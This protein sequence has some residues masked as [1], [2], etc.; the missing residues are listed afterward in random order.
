MAEV[1]PKKIEVETPAPAP[2]PETEVATETPKDVAEEKAVIPLTPPPTEDKP[3][4]SKAL[5][6]IE[7]NLLS[8][9]LA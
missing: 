1:E 6:V 3:D 2:T 5:A 4:E 9:S 7:S 8:L